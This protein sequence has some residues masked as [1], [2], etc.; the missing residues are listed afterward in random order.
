MAMT[1]SA[2]YHAVLATETDENA[3][4]FDLE[5]V[6]CTEQTHTA[7][8]ILRT[9]NA[10]ADLKTLGFTAPSSLTYSQN[11][12]GMVCL[13]IG[14]DEFWLLS[15]KADKDALLNKGEA[16]SGHTALVDNSGAY[17]ALILSGSNVDAL[18]AHHVPYD[19]KQNLPSGKVVSTLFAQ[20]P[21]VIYRTKNETI[22]I[23]RHSFAHSIARLLKQTANRLSSDA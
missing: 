3:R 23:V 9:K 1:K 15:T 10:E 21:T 5:S 11:K 19:L 13:W 7:V 4:L 14:P 17:T 12:A 20:A 18:L 22:L 2:Q 6:Q 16:L 8:V